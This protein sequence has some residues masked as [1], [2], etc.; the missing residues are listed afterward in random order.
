MSFEIF[1]GQKIDYQL[2]IKD[3]QSLK[4]KTGIIV[5]Q[6]SEFTEDEIFISYQLEIAF[7]IERLKTYFWVKDT[8]WYAPYLIGDMM[9]Q[10]NKTFVHGAAISTNNKGILLLAFG[11]I[12]KTCFIANA[13]KRNDV[14]LLGDDLIII[15]ENGKLYPYPR[16]FCLYKYHVKLFP[17][18]FSGK[19]YKFNEYAKNKYWLR[20]KKTLKSKLNIKDKTIYSFLPVAPVHLFSKGKVENKPVDLEAVYIFKKNRKYK[21][22]ECKEDK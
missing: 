5:P 8:T 6:N 2:I 4:L 16:P 13:V 7:K 9:L 18:F 1:K 11:G 22:G 17:Q 21:R 19:T 3:Y 10:Q 14:Q 12:G 15:S 20:A